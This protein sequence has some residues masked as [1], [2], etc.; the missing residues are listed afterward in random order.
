MD[1]P[2]PVPAPAPM[3]A[4]QVNA[5]PKQAQYGAAIRQAVLVASGVVG[6]FGYTHLSTEIGALSL[7][8][9]PAAGLIA[10]ILGQLHTRRAEK[11]QI[12]MATVL[13]DRIATVVRS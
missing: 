13:P 11:Q 1:Q 4:I 7:V 12:A 8:S 10:F 6:A 5:D 2:T 9:G 3:P